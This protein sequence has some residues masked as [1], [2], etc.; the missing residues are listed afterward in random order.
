M[1]LPKPRKYL[2]A[3]FCDSIFGS[4]IYAETK[5]HP[6]GTQEQELHDRILAVDCKYLFLNDLLVEL[7]R[8][9]LATS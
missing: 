1:L 7:A 3:S 8:I 5:T 4:D 2:K 6:S 9:E